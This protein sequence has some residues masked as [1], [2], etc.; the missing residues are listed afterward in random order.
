M[1]AA[2]RTQEWVRQAAVYEVN[3]R[4]Y[5]PEGSFRAF[6]GSLNRLRDMGVSVLWFMPIHPIG[7]QNR[8]GSLGSYYSIRNHCDTN[9]EFGSLD[10][11]RYL[12]GAAKEAGMRVVLDWVANHTAWDHVWT[13]SHPEFYVRDAEGRFQSPYDWSDV[14]QLDHQRIDQQDAMLEAMRFWVKEFD[15]DGFRCDMAHLVPLAFWYR[16]RRELDAI[17]PLFWLAETEEPGY[18]QVFDASYTW[19]FL[20]RMESYWRGQAGMAGLQEVLD[21][22]DRLFPADAIR[23]FFTSNHDE[24]SHSGSEYERMGDAALAFA[25]LCA[26]WKGIPL[27]YSGQELPLRSR[28]DFYHKDRIPWTDPPALQ[29]FYRRLLALRQEHPA[30]RAGDPAVSTRRIASS[31]DQQVFAFL[32]QAGSRAL[33]VVL[34]LNGEGPRQVTLQDRDLNGIFTEVFTGQVLD[35]GRNQQVQL[36]AWGYAVFST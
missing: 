7:V 6:A 18:H 35:M 24:N 29:D 33:L 10:D 27:V 20:H 26:T 3:I 4:Q 11:F 32:R 30:L 28:L 36:P 23:L 34:H 9:P 31:A 22:Y 13:R 15:I 5:T 12:V 16:A 19:E 14:I 1:N 21:R 8:I 25:V 2:F 17:K